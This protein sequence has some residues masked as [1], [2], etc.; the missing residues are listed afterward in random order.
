M[1]DCQV[2]RQVGITKGVEPKRAPA[3]VTHIDCKCRRL[4]LVLE[5]PSYTC[6]ACD[7]RRLS[8]E[9]RGE[10]RRTTMLALSM[11]AVVAAFILAEV[12]MEILR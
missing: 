5:D 2:H 6:A 7:L 9:N 8:R 1:R 10:D 12:A 4:R 11:L 3:P